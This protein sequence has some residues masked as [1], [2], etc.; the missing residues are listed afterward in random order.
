M[1]DPKLQNA[2]LE[3]FTSHDLFIKDDT[4]EVFQAITETDLMARLREKGWRLP[5]AGFFLSDVQEAGFKVQ[6]GYQFS[7][8]VRRK[9]KDGT[10]RAL[11]QY[12]TLIFI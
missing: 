3:I 9:Y 12:Q 5:A 6:Q 1:T 8:K 4:Q 2:I 11:S 10:G 7:G